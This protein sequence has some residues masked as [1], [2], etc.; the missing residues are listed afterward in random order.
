MVVVE[1]FLATSMGNET[2]FLTMMLFV[3]Q[4]FKNVLFSLQS[5]YVEILLSLF[6]N[7]NKQYLI[8]F[9]QEK[10]KIENL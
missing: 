7:I 2:T 4:E 6:L 3:T 8:F 5:S 9:M 10:T 1:I